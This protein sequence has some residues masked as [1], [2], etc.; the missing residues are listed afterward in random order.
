MQDW[1]NMVAVMWRAAIW[2]RA[3]EKQKRS[4]TGGLWSVASCEINCC[5]EDWSSL[6]LAGVYHRMCGG[7]RGLGEQAAGRMGGVHFRPNGWL[8]YVMKFSEGVKNAEWLL[9]TVLKRMIHMN[10]MSLLLVNEDVKQGKPY[11]GLTG[12]S[13]HSIHFP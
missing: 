3:L 6:V 1:V 7:E 11:A 5:T 8:C 4:E 10:L 9:F 13:N 2:W 12:T